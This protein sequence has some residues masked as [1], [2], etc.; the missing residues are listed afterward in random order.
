[1]KGQAAYELKVI[2]PEAGVVGVGGDT[3]RVAR[4]AEVGGV[5][6]GVVYRVAA[7]E[8]QVHIRRHAWAAATA[9][10]RG[11]G[12]SRRMSRH[13][14]AR[15]V[16]VVARDAPVHAQMVIVG[17]VSD[18]PDDRELIGDGGLSRQQLTELNAG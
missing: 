15:G 16:G 1:I 10:P 7:L 4:A 2:D 13:E 3:K 17:S 11:H 18:A 8:A 14:V 12:A 6:I 5:V 9:E